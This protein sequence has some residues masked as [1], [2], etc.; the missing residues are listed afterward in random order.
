MSAGWGGTWGWS[1]R[2]H[3]AAQ[4]AFPA[5]DGSRSLRRE[6]PLAYHF[7]G[8]RCLPSS[9]KPGTPTGR[10][11][12]WGRPT[13]PPRP[14]AWTRTCSWEQSQARRKS[15]QKSRKDIKG[16]S[17]RHRNYDPTK[18]Q[19]NALGK[20]LR[21]SKSGARTVPLLFWSNGNLTMCSL[22]ADFVLRKKDDI[23][24]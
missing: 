11:L 12:S 19:R 6:A 16:F 1:L 9:S 3:H 22:L 21:C 13:S 15:S 7:P 20:V 10:E 18:K 5:L 2:P 17:L 24:V 14:C 4:W 8:S 23:Q